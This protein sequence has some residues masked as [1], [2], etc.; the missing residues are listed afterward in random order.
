MPEVEDIIGAARSHSVGV[1]GGG[2]GGLIVAYQCAKVGIPVTVWEAQADIGGA[3]RTVELDGAVVEAGADSFDNGGDLASLIAEFG[4]TELSELSPL[5]SR[6]LTGET[7][8][9]LPD[10]AVLGVPANPFDPDVKAIIGWGGVWRAYLDRLKPVLTIGREKGVGEV[11]SDRMGARV[12]DRLVAPITRAEFRVEP[13]EV[14]VD[15]AVPGLNAALTRAGSLSGGVAQLDKSAPRHFLRGGLSQLTAAL[16]QRITE[17]GGSVLTGTPVA[18]IENGEYWEVH[19]ATD[20]AEQI[21]K[22]THLVIAADET[23]SLDLL[24]PIAPRLPEPRVWPVTIVTMTLDADVPQ[25]GAGF[26]AATST[27]PIRIADHQSA[28]FP[29]QSRRENQGVMRV[30]IDGHD[31]ADDEALATARAAVTHLY[32]ADA[33]PVSTRVDRFVHSDRR[34]SIHFFERSSHIAAAIAGLEGLEAAGGWIAGAGIESVASHAVETAERIRRSVL[35]PA[36]EV[37]AGKGI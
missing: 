11:V 27:E 17:L 6:W 30:E 3:I 21:T 13:D 9:H 14:I 35:F 1:V 20:D 5:T 12:R 24:A 31:L 16:A 22:V 7:P 23:A 25:R 10:D 29:E 4:F 18:R 37:D 32:G 28:R 33:S 8:H 34:A 26:Y 2:L 19:T 36:N 15:E